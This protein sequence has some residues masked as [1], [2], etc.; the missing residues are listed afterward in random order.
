[1]TLGVYKLDLISTPVGLGVVCDSTIP[2][3]A[4]VVEY[5]GEVL[6]GVDTQKRVDRRYQVEL[7]PKAI[8]DGLTDVF[9]D[10]DRCGNESRFVNHACRL[11]CGVFELEWTNTARLGIFAKEDIPPLRELT[12]CYR[13]AN[14]SLFT[15]MRARKLHLK[16][17]V[18]LNS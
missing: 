7:K 11:N 1:M 2:K 18:V 4:F 15:C 10:A 8:W 14:L 17:P 9:I 6:L 5:V 12:I 3:D 16:A 13:K